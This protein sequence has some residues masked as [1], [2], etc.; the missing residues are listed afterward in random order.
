MPYILDQIPLLTTAQKNTFA[1][2]KGTTV[3]KSADDVLN[4]FLC[5]FEYW[6]TPSP[7]ET[8]WAVY[9]SMHHS[10]FEKALDAWLSEYDPLHN[11]DGKEKTI[12]LKSEGKTTITDDGESHTSPD[13]TRNKVTTQATEGAQTE[14]TTENEVTTYDSQTP[15]LDNKST[16]TSAPTGGEETIYNLKTDTETDNTNTRERT[17]TTI[18]HDG[19]TYTAHD[20][21]INELEKGGN[22]GVTTSQQM[23]QSEV[24]MRLKPLIKMYLDTFIKEYAYCVE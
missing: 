2:K 8:A 7:I 16:V 14:T 5:T 22:L 6:K 4:Y 9:E 18:T 10:D 1:L 21:E 20:I 17:N 13:S 12:L 15:R 11:Y 3:I 19:K 24:E 23:I